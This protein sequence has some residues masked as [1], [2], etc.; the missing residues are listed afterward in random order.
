MID[1]NGVGYLVSASSR[2]LRDLVAGGAGDL[3]GR[4]HRAR[5]RDRALRLPRDGGARLV[6]HPDDGAGRR[7]A[8]RAVDPV[9]PVAR[10]DRARHRRRRQGEPQPARRRRTQARRASRHR[11][12]G[13]GRRVRRGARAG[14]RDRRGG[15]RGGRVGQRGRGVGAGQS[16]LSPGRG[17]RRRRARDA[18]SRPG[19]AARCRDP[20][21]ACRSWRDERPAARRGPPIGS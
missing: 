9:D 6:P 17:V 20:G 19:C 8:G 2:T 3:A 15:A 10:R 11:A 1:V 21:A 13:Q 7:R 14:A 5:G 12:Q 4:D 16:R 18:A